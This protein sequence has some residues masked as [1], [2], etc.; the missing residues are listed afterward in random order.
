MP[1]FRFLFFFLIFNLDILSCLNFYISEAFH[2]V[3][4]NH[5][6]IYSSTSEL[7]ITVF[8]EIDVILKL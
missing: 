8:I 1:I 2:N 4:S 7:K 6:Y 5:K 3:R